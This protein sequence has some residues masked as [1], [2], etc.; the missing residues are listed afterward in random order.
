MSDLLNLLLIHTSSKKNLSNELL[1]ML[2]LCI[3][4]IRN[5]C[6]IFS[7]LDMHAQFSVNQ[8]RPEDITM[9]E[10]L[11]SIAFVGDDGFGECQGPVSVFTVIIAIKLCSYV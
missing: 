11:S 1:P 9:R 7:D 5:G 4:L 8:S 10:D 3:V 2:N 6:L